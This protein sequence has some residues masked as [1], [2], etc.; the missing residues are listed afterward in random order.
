MTKKQTVDSQNVAGKSKT[1]P[2]TITQINADKLT[3]VTFDHNID[4]F[5]FL[6]LPLCRNLENKPFYLFIIISI[7][8]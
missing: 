5:L 3:L 4:Q 8:S 2:V 6:A 7:F 1:G